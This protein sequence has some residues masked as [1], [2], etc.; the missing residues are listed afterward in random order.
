MFKRLF[1]FLS[2]SLVLLFLSALLPPCE[3]ETACKKEFTLKLKHDFGADSLRRIE[4]PG[5][6]FSGYLLSDRLFG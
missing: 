2:A 1:M 5:C 6:I 4:S 3:V